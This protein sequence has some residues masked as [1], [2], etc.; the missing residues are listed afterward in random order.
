M[1]KVC[2]NVSGGFRTDWGAQIFFTIKSY[3][4]TFLKHG[5]DVWTGRIKAMKGFPLSL[6]RLILPV[7]FP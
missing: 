4:G 2:E 7:F 3:I 6:Q 1:V 5:R